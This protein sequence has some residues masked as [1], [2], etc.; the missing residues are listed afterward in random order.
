[1][2]KWTVDDGVTTMTFKVNPFDMST[3]FPPKNLQVSTPLNLVTM[4]PATAPDFSFNGN[5]YS[6][7]E[8]DT[9][10]EWHSKGLLLLLNDHLGRTFS[11]V[12]SKLD[13]TDRRDTARNN[14]RYTYTWTVLNLGRV[15]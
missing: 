7:E 13:I 11:V 15:E 8:Y 4:Q 2:I 6:D 9:L 12:S 10:V 14:E 1:M 5:A 3:P